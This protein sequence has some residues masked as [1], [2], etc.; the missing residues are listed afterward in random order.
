MKSGVFWSLR[1]CLMSSGVFWSIHV[2]I[3]LISDMTL[4]NWVEGSILK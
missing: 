2:V 3:M 1:I 4:I